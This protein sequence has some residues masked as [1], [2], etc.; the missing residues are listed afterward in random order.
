M[1]QGVN[2]DGRVVV[3]ASARSTIVK[4]GGEVQGLGEEQDLD[5]LPGEQETR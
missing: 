1:V 3:G 4:I 2:R 5:L